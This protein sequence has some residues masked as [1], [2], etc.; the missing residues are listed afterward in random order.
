M[1]SYNSTIKYL[2][3]SKSKI[4]LQSNII[5]TYQ[6]TSD[7]TQKQGI[8][9]IPS[10]KINVFPVKH[11][12]NDDLIKKLASMMEMDKVYDVKKIYIPIWMC[13]LAIETKYEWH[14]HK[15]NFIN[16]TEIFSSITATRPICI[17]GTDNYEFKT[18]NFNQIINIDN[19]IDHKWGIK[20]L[21]IKEGW[22]QKLKSKI[23]RG[24]M[25]NQNSNNIFNDLIPIQ[26]NIFDIDLKDNIPS[27]V[28]PFKTNP[29][30]L[31]LRIPRDSIGKFKGI[32][33]DKVNT[34]I[35]QFEIKLFN[36]YPIYRPIYLIN[37]IYRG[38]TSL[39][40]LCFDAYSGKVLSQVDKSGACLS[41]FD[42][43]YLPDV[44]F[45]KGLS[46]AQ[47]YIDNNFDNTEL[48]ST[49]INWNSQLIQSFIDKGIENQ[50]WL[51]LLY[52]TERA[53]IIARNQWFKF[54]LDIL[55]NKKNSI[56]DIGRKLLT[57]E[58]FSR[59]YHSPLLW[60]KHYRCNRIKDLFYITLRDHLKK[61]MPLWIPK[62]DFTQHQIIN[63][64]MKNTKNNINSYFDFEKSINSQKQKEFSPPPPFNNQEYKK[65]SPSPSPPPPPPRSKSSK[66]F[67]NQEFKKQSPSPPPPPPPPSPPPQRPK[68]SKSF[69]NQEFKKQPSPP[70]SPSPPPKSNETIYDPQG[71]YRILGLS[72]I[73]YIPNDER[74]K[75]AFT[76]I[77]KTIEIQFGAHMNLNRNQKNQK[78]L[79]IRKVLE[80]REA[81]KTQNK[82]IEYSNKKKGVQ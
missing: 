41:Y 38:G 63:R 56:K 39:Y 19:S 55:T 18:L 77:L 53:R 54:V 69:N 79:M 65:Q 59:R 81:L 9:L 16:G 75:L 35:L 10:Y 50:N 8:L 21:I 32:Y 24:E 72:F 7:I 14:Y 57:F 61:T 51:R 74:I 49:P 26:N 60:F 20:P 66:S 15:S 40:K 1:K 22:I 45:S 62:I 31:I 34:N 52:R 27:I 11:Y 58:E 82:R 4:T 48:Y 67:N 68:S 3:Y 36:L 70:S 76:S 17:H 44:P 42:H 25:S 33:D 12:Y 28:L 46:L 64:S 23:F 2:K 73:T 29:I 78:D 43:P 13:S 30:N 37:Y 71:Y 5:R 80:A 6:S 47:N